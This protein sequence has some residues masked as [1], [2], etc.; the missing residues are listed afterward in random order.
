MS[1][2]SVPVVDYGARPKSGWGAKWTL[3]IVGG[4]VGIGLF[5]MLFVPMMCQPRE[6][7]NRIK[8]QSNLRQLGLAMTMYANANGHALPGSWA[9]LAA[10]S[11]LTADV[12]ISPSSDDDRSTE[13][14][15]ARWGPALD[16]P[17]TRTCSYRYAGD[18]L[19]E[20]QAKDDKTVLAFEPSDHN[21]GDGIHILFGDGHVDWYAIGKE[22]PTQQQYQKLLADNAAHVRPLQ[23]IY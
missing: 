17:H 20:A 21:S 6:G 5:F 13:K 4:I 19:T 14:D 1:S 9:E 8:S 12:F 22:G 10:N 16:D 15:P 11:E 3:W 7:A 2:V 18:G 23:W